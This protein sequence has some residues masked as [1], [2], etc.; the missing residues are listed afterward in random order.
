MRSPSIDYLHTKLEKQI[1]LAEGYT[2]IKGLNFIIKA[3]RLK[4]YDYIFREKDNKIILHRWW[5]DEFGNSFEITKKKKIRITYNDLRLDRD[6]IVGTDLYYGLSIDQV[7]KMSKLVH[8]LS[9]KDEDEF[10]PCSILTFLG[11]DDHLRSYLNWSG[12]W[13]QVSPLILGMKNLEAIAKHLD[14][15][16]YQE[17]KENSVLPCVDGRSFLSY[18]PASVNFLELLKKRYEHI[19]YTLDSK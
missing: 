16:H 3:C 8:L 9:G 6:K 14:I 15:K 10:K 5:I 1:R 17:K 11:I 12:E 18:M 7:A 2:E 4:P 19:Y 13:A